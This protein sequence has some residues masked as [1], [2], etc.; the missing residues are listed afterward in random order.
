M[1]AC[2]VKVEIA[3]QAEPIALRFELYF[4]SSGHL[5]LRANGVHLV[6]LV[7]PDGTACTGIDSMLKANLDALRRSLGCC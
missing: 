2:K 5:C 7:N 3:G 1:S 4:K 6:D